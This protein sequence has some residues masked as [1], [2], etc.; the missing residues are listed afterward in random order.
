MLLSS[1]A[2]AAALPPPTLLCRLP[3]AVPSPPLLGAPPTHDVAKPRGKPRSLK[4][5]WV[6]Q[7]GDKNLVTVTVTGDDKMLFSYDFKLTPQGKKLPARTQKKVQEI[8]AGIQ[9]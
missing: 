6:E 9:E 5:K 4:G 1:A 8:L 2:A 7:P 3:P